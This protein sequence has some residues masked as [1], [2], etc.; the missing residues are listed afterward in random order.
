MMQQELGRVTK[1]KCRARAK[2]VRNAEKRK[3]RRAGEREET[4]GSRVVGLWEI[5]STK[6][7]LAFVCFFCLSCPL[8]L[9][10]LIVYCICN[11]LSKTQEGQLD[12]SKD[13]EMKLQRKK[14]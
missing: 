4:A 1:E 7:S 9:S 10:S 3:Q 2:V 6:A 5:G 12:G 8:C 14:G 11:H 13:E